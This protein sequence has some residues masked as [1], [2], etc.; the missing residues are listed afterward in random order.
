[1]FVIG[2]IEYICIRYRSPTEIALVVQSIA[3]A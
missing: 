2:N 3:L 1:M